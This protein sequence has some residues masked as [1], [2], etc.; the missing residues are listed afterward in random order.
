MLESNCDLID[1]DAVCNHIVRFMIIQF[2]AV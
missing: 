2:K 1:L